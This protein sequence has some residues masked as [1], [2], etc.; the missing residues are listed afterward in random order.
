MVKWTEKGSLS[1]H[2]IKL[3]SKLTSKENELITPKAVY[4]EYRINYV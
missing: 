1:K 4:N 2:S 3:Y